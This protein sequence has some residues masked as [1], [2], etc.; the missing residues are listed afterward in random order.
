MT[1][2][3]PALTRRG[4]LM[5]RCPWTAAALLL[6]VAPLAPRT[7]SGQC[8][9]ET[10]LP[11]PRPTPMLDQRTR[12]ERIGVI[13]TDAATFY[14]GP[15]RGDRI[16]RDWGFL[17]PLLVYNERG[18]FLLVGTKGG[19]DV[20]WVHRDDFL[21]SQQCLKD[22]RHKTWRKALVVNNILASSSD[23]LEFNT[24]P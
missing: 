21:A 14:C 6:A 1:A 8:S 16:S 22:D 3:E 5:T 20:A 12:S 10:L 11:E 19:E 18:R 9:V 2:P 13:V 17:S 4:G 23:G 15:R 24:I 7:S